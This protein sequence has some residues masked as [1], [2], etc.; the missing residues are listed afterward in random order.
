MLALTFVVA[1]LIKVRKPWASKSALEASFLN[2][3]NRKYLVLIDSFNLIVVFPTGFQEMAF[4][5]MTTTATTA[6]TTTTTT[7]AAT[8]TIMMKPKRTSPVKKSA[9]V[10]DFSPFK[11]LIGL[12]KLQ[13]EW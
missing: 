11:I 1:F 5:T 9:N 6:T 3:P 7:A 10:N 13:C 8:T 2:E 4:Y 12:V